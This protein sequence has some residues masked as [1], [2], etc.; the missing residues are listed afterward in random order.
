[1]N[2]HIKRFQLAAQALVY[3]GVLGVALESGIVSAHRPSPALNSSTPVV[4]QSSQYPDWLLP[5]GGMSLVI[6]SFGIELYRHRCFLDSDT[7][8]TV[9]MQPKIAEPT[10]HTESATEQDYE[11]PYPA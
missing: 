1:M 11:S 6:I 5:I 4:E 3:T 10:Q 8:D 7:Q 9:P 2:K